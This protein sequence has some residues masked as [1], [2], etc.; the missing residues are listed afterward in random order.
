MKMSNSEHKLKKWLNIQFDRLDRRNLLNWLSDSSYLKIRFWLKMGKKLE[1]NNPK[2]FNEKLQFLKLHDRNPKYTE[3]VDKYE[4]REYIKNELG[5]EYLIPILAVYD[6]FEDI[7]FEE[8]PEQF[9]LKCTHDSGGLVV[10]T[11][12]SKLDIEAARNKINKCLEQNYYYRGREYPYKNVVPRII[13]EK[14][15][16]EDDLGTGLKD[17]KFMCFN[18]E[19]KC[20]FICLNRNS[21]EG[22]NIDFYDVNWNK[23]PFERYYP[24]SDTLLP[25]PQNYNQ[26]INFAEKLAKDI[27]FIRVDFYEIH[28][29]LYFGEL[30]LYPGSGFEGFSPESYDHI[31]GDWI[32]LPRR[33]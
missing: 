29:R 20:S 26:M 13:C 18:G 31:L 27:P 28:G 15:M 2:T 5:E 23:M 4:V 14:Y 32:K 9:V 3:M 7:N 21:V 6:K 22:L 19:V 17:Y 16:V 30:T 12:K 11:D 10:C 25:K 8:L 1:L 24:N 33:Q